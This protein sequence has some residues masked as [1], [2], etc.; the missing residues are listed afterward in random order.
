MNSGH[1]RRV[2]TEAQATANRCVADLKARPHLTVG[3]RTSEGM[4]TDDPQRH[5]PALIAPRTRSK[6]PDS[7]P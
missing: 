7:I 3:C 2:R 1:A 5:A 4:V 6:R